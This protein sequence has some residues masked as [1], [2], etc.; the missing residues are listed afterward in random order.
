MADWLDDFEQRRE[1]FELVCDE[2]NDLQA[3]SINSIQQRRKYEV[4]FKPLHQIDG[5]E[6]DVSL[7]SHMTIWRSSDDGQIR[8]IWITVPR[9]ALPYTWLDK[10]TV[11][12]NKYGIDIR[13]EN[14]SRCLPWAGH[15][16]ATIPNERFFTAGNKEE[17]IW[18]WESVPHLNYGAINQVL[19]RDSQTP[20]DY[21]SFSKIRSTCKALPQVMTPTQVANPQIYRPCQN[22]ALWLFNEYL[23]FYYPDGGDF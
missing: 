18:L 14:Y 22:D 7:S 10:R 3:G 9:S 6:V 20:T 5:S 16:S 11:H 8:G 13:D 19:T 2:Y 1:A 17:L 15:A 21:G 4:T 12:F 23:K